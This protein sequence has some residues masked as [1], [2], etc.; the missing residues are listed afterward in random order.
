MRLKKASKIGSVFIEAIS[1]VFNFSWLLIGP[2]LKN[3][4][5]QPSVFYVQSTALAP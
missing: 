2:A 5:H 3:S 4:Y 1:L